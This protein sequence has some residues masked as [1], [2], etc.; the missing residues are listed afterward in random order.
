MTPFG[1]ELRCGT[2]DPGTAARASSSSRMSAV[3]M[4][5]S[6]RQKNRRYPTTP[7]LG[8]A[9]DG[10]GWAESMWSEGRSGSTP[11]SPSERVRDAKAG[12][13]RGDEGAP[14]ARH[15]QRADEDEQHAARDVDGA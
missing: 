13:E 4:L 7:S 11:P 6:W 3:R 1:S 5:V 12:S 10:S 8:C 9:I 14:D 2:S 15:H